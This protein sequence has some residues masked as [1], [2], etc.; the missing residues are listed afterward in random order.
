MRAF[1]RRLRAVETLGT[2]SVI[3]TDKTG[4]LIKNEMTVC[5]FMLDQRR[6]EVTG[7]GYSVDGTFQEW[8]KSVDL[9]TDEHLAL[10]FWIGMLCND[11]K[12]ERCNGDQ[13][14]LGDLTEAVLIV[15]AQEAKI[16]LAKS[17]K[18]YP[19]ISEVPFDSVSKS[20][21]TVQ[22]PAAEI[23]AQLGMGI[24]GKGNR[25]RTVHGGE[26]KGLH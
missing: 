10:A 4:T 12:V 26:L 15:V 22:W 19:R 5:V 18:Q 3:C 7:S 9:K 8:D 25:L 23:A 2:T 17:K 20:I 1:V 11:A 13:T 24:D 14:V 6:I 21:F 16:S